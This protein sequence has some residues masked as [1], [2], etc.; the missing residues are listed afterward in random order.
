MSDVAENPKKHKFVIKPSRSFFS[1]DWR[2]MW[3]YRDLLGLLVHR[4]LVAIYKQTILGPLW[5][6][7]QPLVTTLVFT[8]IFG[9]LAKIST[10]GM[11]KTL[12][13]MSGVMFWTYFH[14]CTQNVGVSLIGNAPLF[15]KVYYPRLISPL[16]VV[17]SNLAQFGL[18]L[19]V[20][21]SL[22]FYYLFFTTA[23]IHPTWWLLALPLLV[24]ESAMIGLG[25][26]LCIAAMTIKYR[27]LTFAIPF[28]MQLWMYAS[29]I[30][31]PTS[32]MSERWRWLLMLNPMASVVEQGRMAFLG[33]GTL[34]PAY[35]LSGWGLGFLL[36]VVGVVLFQRAQRTF[37]D[38]I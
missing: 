24:I 30:V 28:I 6:I 1:I 38:T 20:F 26:G 16:A 27:D 32:L 21:L 15:R 25:V 19:L 9:N 34:T 2:E 17:I 5:I 4:D 22:Y 13:Y 11:P 12:F 37:V 8:V 33:T 31:Y 23:S 14:N 3:L 36:L 29:P 7:I 10:D 35:V 18:N